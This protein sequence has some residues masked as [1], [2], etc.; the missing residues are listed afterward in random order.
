MC[1]MDVF[2][3]IF[4]LWRSIN[5]KSKTGHSTDHT[6][7]PQTCPAGFSMLLGVGVLL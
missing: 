7:G 6:T 3:F 1:D 2:T 4:Y 5:K